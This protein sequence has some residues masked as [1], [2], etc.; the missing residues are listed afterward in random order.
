MY[1]QYNCEYCGR[2][3]YEE[4]GCWNQDHMFFCEIECWEAWSIEEGEDYDYN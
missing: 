3:Q 2:V 1:S 4:L